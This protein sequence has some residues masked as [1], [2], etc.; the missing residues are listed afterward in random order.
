MNTDWNGFR[1]AH[2]HPG[3]SRIEPIGSATGALACSLSVLIRVHPWFI[4]FSLHRRRKV[5]EQV[6]KLLWA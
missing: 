1:K 5:L 4:L 6:S 2:F 3:I